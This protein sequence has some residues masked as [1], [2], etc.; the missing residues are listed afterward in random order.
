VPPLKSFHRKGLEQVAVR[1]AWI[2]FS[3]PAEGTLEGRW[4]IILFRLFLTELIYFLG[5]W[6]LKGEP[7]F[8][9]L[10]P[11]EKLTRIIHGLP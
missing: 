2:L 9:L 1:G 4:A 8:E 5:F 10:F 6:G 7:P 11:I 3:L